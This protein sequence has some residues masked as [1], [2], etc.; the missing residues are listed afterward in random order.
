MGNAE[1]RSAEIVLGDDTLTTAAAARWSRSPAG[2]TVRIAEDAVAR[3]DG[4]VR[5]R[6]AHVA[7]GR[8][9][10]A[11]TTGPGEEVLRAAGL[12]PVTF[13]AKEGLALINGTSFMSGFAALAA[14]DGAEIAVVADLCTALT[15]ETLLGDSGHFHPLIHRQKPHPG[16]IRSAARILAL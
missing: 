8:P 5:V 6:D 1:V 4:S 3:M 15:T 12:E 16:Q 14:H 10:Y 2:A 9:V 11:S 13:E 7:T